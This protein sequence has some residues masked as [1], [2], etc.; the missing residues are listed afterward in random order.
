M[1]GAV[2]G[3]GVG[4]L[5]IQ[6]GYQRN[7]VDGM[8]ITVVVSVGIVGISPLVGDMLSRLVNHR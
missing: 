6:Y 3:G 7:Q 4:D 8:V 2:G 1:A 5:A